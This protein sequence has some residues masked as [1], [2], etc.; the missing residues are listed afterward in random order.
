MSTEWTDLGSLNTSNDRFR[1]PEP[2]WSSPPQSSFWRGNEVIQYGISKQSIRVLT[3]WYVGDR[4]SYNFLNLT[5]NDEFKILS[6]F[7]NHKGRLNKFWLPVRNSF[8]MPNVDIAN[9]SY[10]FECVNMSNVIGY[11]RVFFLLMNGDYITR[12][13]M[14]YSPS[15]GGYLVNTAFDIAIPVANVSYAGKFILCRFDQDELEFK[16]E[17]DQVSSVNIAFKELPMEY[18]DL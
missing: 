2:D 13:I 8:Y 14:F 5:K 15:S 12:Q 17:N 3:S 9:G 6:F 1:S 18:A 10:Y 11:E 4:V 16:H 7:Y